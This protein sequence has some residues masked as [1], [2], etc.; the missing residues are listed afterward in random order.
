MTQ[1]PLWT[2]FDDIVARWVGPGAPTDEELVTALILDAEAVITSEYPAI[3]GRIFGGSLPLQVVQMVT[4]RMVI[5]VLRNPETVSYWQ[6]QT[7]PFGQ[8]RNFGENVDIWLTENEKN[9]LAPNTR[10][11]AFS[12]NLAPDAMTPVPDLFEGMDW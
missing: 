6:Q 10:G 3:N 2:T 4:A 11:K 9:M 8:A 1:T 7:G 12:L 5:R